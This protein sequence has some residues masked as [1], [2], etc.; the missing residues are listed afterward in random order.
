MFIFRKSE[1]QT[2]TKILKKRLPASC[3][4]VSGGVQRN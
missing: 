1:Y 3:E 2:S 4:G